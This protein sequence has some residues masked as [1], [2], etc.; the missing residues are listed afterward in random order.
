MDFALF[1]FYHCL[2][3]ILGFIDFFHHLNEK[4]FKELITKYI[5]PSISRTNGGDVCPGTT[6]VGE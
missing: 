3:V 4:H 5:R 1:C 2:F 6:K